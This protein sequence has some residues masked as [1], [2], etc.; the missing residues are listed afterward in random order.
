MSSICVDC[1]R[2]Y[3]I[4]FFDRINTG[5]KF[6]HF[7]TCLCCGVDLRVN[8]TSTRVSFKSHGLTGKMWSADTDVIRVKCVEILRKLC[9]DRVSSFFAP[10]RI[11]GQYINHAPST[12]LPYSKG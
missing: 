4:A 10:R 3:N 5:L 12:H 9:V 6:S 2:T 1:S 8:V 7:P 11:R